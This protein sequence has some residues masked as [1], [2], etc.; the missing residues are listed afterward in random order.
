MRSAARGLRVLTA[1]T[2]TL[3]VAVG[4]LGVGAGAVA[5]D[6][7]GP[8]PRG[9]SGIAGLINQIA[10]VDQRLADIDASLAIKREAANRAL[11]D[12]QTSRD[13]E[14]LSVLAV[15][16]SSDALKKAD[17]QIATAQKNFDDFVRDLYRQGSNQASLAT[18]FTSGDPAAV[19]DRAGVIAQLTK[20]QQATIQQLKVSR[21]EKANKLAT[22]TATRKS[23]ARAA[24]QAAQRKQ[25]AVDAIAQT[26]AAAK[27]ESATKAQLS[28]A[29]DAAQQQL[30]ALRGRVPAAAP[31]TVPGGA[32]GST[33]AAAPAPS[34]GGV[35]AVI[36]G[37]VDAASPIDPLR[38]AI[39][40]AAQSAFQIAAQAAAKLAV[41]AA[42]QVVAQ[43]IAS[44]T[45]NHTDIDGTDGGSGTSSGGSGGGGATSVTPGVTGSAAVEIV[46]N[47]A[48][49]QLGVP[50]SWGGGNANGPTKGIR[51]GGV[52]DSYGDYNKVGFDCSGLMMYAFAGI[53][54]SLPHYTGYQYTSGPHVPLSQMQR[55]DMIFYGPNASQHVALYLGNNQMVEAPESGSVV[56]ISPLRTS[57]AM[58]Y[59]VRLTG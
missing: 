1:A 57:G 10:D 12:L 30:D 45:G 11:V 48:L 14:R 33:P 2:V 38:D 51:D 16:G 7:A 41:D 3:L 34:P 43:V 37:R 17:A 26:V 42:Q 9:P 56:K 32:P 58:P 49:S 21:N 6:P 46:V 20:D 47:R 23:A 36:P 18:V 22:A 44:I 4:L 35:A 13:Q 5:A 19:L 15:N 31:V 8:A 53:G 28:A 24:E 39:V 29:R 50:Y 25:D 40:T 55:G 54:I 59:V 52:A 27:T